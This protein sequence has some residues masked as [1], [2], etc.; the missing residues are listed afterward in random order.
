MRLYREYW[1]GLAAAAAVGA[2]VAFASGSAHAGVLVNGDFEQPYA[3]YGLPPGWIDS[4]VVFGGPINAPDVF[5]VKGSDYIPCCGATGTPVALANNFVTFGAGDSPNFGGVL[6]QQFSTV[7]GR[8]YQVSFDLGVLGARGSQAFNVRL[9]DLTHNVI[10]ANQTFVGL[11]DNDLDTTF[12]H[13]G[14]SFTAT[15]DTTLIAFRDISEI[16]NNIDGA[17][18]NVA[19]SGAPEPAAWAMMILGFGFAGALARRRRAML[20]AL[21]S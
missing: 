11:N 10:D 4:N 9:T 5:T 15:G 16:T 17:I 21:A 12:H 19:I 7:V 20:E 2:I 6:G 18:D 1:I 3:P 8:T 13:H 14:F